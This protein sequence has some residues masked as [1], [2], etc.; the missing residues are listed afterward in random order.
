M[1]EVSLIICILV[2]SIACFAQN[3]PQISADWQNYV[4]PKDEFAV[5]I[6]QK[7]EESFHTQN[8]SDGQKIYT[9][10]RYSTTYKNNFY[11]AFSQVIDKENNIPNELPVT[12]L[13]KFVNENSGNFQST[14][15]GEVS[16]EIAIFKDSENFF[17][18]IVFIKT[19]K[20]FYVF[21]TFGSEEDN[22]DFQRFWLSLRFRQIEDSPF[23][24][25]FATIKRQKIQNSSSGSGQGLGQGSGQ[26]GGSGTRNGIGNGGS[27]PPS[28]NQNSSLKILSKPRANY[29]DL[30]RIYQIQ[31][32]ITF[33]V[34]FLASGAIGSVTPLSKLPFGLTQNAITALKQIRFEPAVKDGVPYN[35]VKMVQYS[36]TLY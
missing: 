29:T 13:K 12:Q 11:Y 18:K 23:A 16:G 1:K 20:R 33:R 6:P 14:K 36:F 4:S 26:G 30:A 31:G 7:M 9:S 15:I 8:D 21:H 32:N 10:G 2:F 22:P 35:V 27:S 24:K 3:T 28:P 25:P 5:D 34:I 17:H 19:E